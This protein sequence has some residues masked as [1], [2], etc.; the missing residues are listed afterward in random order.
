M[1]V[2]LGWG[3][4][5]WNPGTLPVLGEW[6][7]D[8]PFLPVEFGRQSQDGQIT[9][10]I[11]DS[12]LVFSVLWAK[13]DIGDLADAREALRAREKIPRSNAEQD[14]AHWSRSNGASDRRETEVIA[15]WAAGKPEIEA[16]V[17]TAL[18]PKFGG[19]PGRMPTEQEVIAYLR[20][21]EGKRLSDAEKYIRCAPPQ[22]R[23]T[24]RDAIETALGWTP[25]APE[26]CRSSD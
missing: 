12:L 14:I 18:P 13:L 11:N 1:I 7:P 17:W 25:L 2:C 16:V 4:L 24:Y 5:V 15:V 6:Q 19:E 22:I 26:A 23:T 8:G 10:I 3:S 21:L 9:L 20:T